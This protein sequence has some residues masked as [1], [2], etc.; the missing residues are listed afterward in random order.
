MSCE[1][2]LLLLVPG[3]ISLGRAILMSTRSDIMAGDNFGL[4]IM[5]GW[6]LTRY[7]KRKD[8]SKHTQLGAIVQYFLFMYKPFKIILILKIGPRPKKEQ[9]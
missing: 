3:A 6:S 7:R 2:P 8:G 5:S 4:R 1:A 9:V